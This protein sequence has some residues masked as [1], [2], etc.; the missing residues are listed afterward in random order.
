MDFCSFISRHSLELLF[1]EDVRH[2][3]FLGEWMKRGSE[4][5]VK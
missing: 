5:E 4:K 3:R 1:I 2:L